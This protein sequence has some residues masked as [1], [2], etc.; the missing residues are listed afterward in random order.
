MQKNYKYLRI[1]AQSQSELIYYQQIEGMTKKSSNYLTFILKL[2][3]VEKF[4]SDVNV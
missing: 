4:E 3:S 1:M 2:N